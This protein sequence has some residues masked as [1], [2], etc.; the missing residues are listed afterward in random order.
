MEFIEHIA[1]GALTVMPEEAATQD[2]FAALVRRQSR[3][4]FRVAYAV[5]RNR[6]DAEDVAQEVFWK[7]HRTGAW[8]AID[9]EPAF[10]A[11]A[12]WRMAVDRRPRRAF[13]P[14]PELPVASHEQNVLDDDLHTLVHRLIDELPDELR[15]VLALT[16]VQELNSRQIAELLATP[17]GTVRTRLARARQVLKEKLAIAL[18]RRR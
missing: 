6:A 3:L 5:L 2:G 8:R 9:D 14:V 4:V 15:L 11:R 7:L 10:L 1:L 13:A 12:T 16:A 18:E 17:E